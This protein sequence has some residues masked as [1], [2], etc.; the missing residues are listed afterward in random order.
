V[1]AVDYYFGVFGHWTDRQSAISDLRLRIAHI[2]AHLVDGDPSFTNPEQKYI[3][4]SR[5]FVDLMVGLNPLLLFGS[6]TT[7][8]ALDDEMWGRG[9]IRLRPYAGAMWL[10]NTIPDTLGVITPYAGLD[11]HMELLQGPIPVTLRVGYEAR[12]NSELEPV[13]EHLVRLGLKLAPWNTTGVL[14]EGTYYAGRSPYGQYFDRREKFFSIGF[15]IG[16]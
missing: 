11:G 13:G 8:R 14:I 3:T 5:E 16:M 9:R 10:F 6:S 1:E 7:G 12:L 15:A 4:Y 2:S